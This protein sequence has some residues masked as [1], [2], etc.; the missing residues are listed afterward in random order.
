MAKYKAE[1]KLYAVVEFQDDGVND[2]KDQAFEALSL[3]GVDLKEFDAELLGEP[4]K[5]PNQC[6]I[7][8]PSS[9]LSASRCA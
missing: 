3:M 1:F 7:H 2:V 4:T 8:P 5:E 9:P 6:P